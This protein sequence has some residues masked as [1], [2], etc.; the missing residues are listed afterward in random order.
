MVKV[1]RANV[2]LRVKEADVPNYLNMGYSVIGENGEILT[3]AIPV[4]VHVLQAAWV[5][6]KKKIEELEQTN[7]ELKA[8]LAKA[9]K[10]AKA[11]K[12]VSS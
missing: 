7:A 4:D 8:K 1:R 3:E 11:A 9:E 2:I 10:A 12:K 6:N 5:D